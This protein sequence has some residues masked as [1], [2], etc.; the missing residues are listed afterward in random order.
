MHADRGA[1]LTPVLQE[2]V[3]TI[4]TQVK[5]LRQ[6]ASEFSSFAGS[7]TAKPASVDVPEMLRRSLSHGTLGSDPF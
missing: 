7:P 1:P 3:E 4:L 6:I 5:L 2:C